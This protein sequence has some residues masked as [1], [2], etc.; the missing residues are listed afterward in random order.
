MASFEKAKIIKDSSGDY[1]LI[2]AGVRVFIDTDKEKFMSGMEQLVRLWP[3]LKDV[4][5]NMIDSGRG[6]IMAVLPPPREE[7]RIPVKF[8]GAHTGYFWILPDSVSL[9]EAAVQLYGPDHAD[10]VGFWWWFA[11]NHPEAFKRTLAFA[12]G[13][14]D[15]G[16]EIKKSFTW[17]YALG[18]I[19]VA[20]LLLN[21]I[22][23]MQRGRR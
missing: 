14:D 23:G 16:K 13:V 2:P 9:N 11:T 19:A 5:I 22:S 20:I 15:A 4:N 10:P 3:E 17:I 21:V 1:I 8:A 6:Q 18:G 12:E 7:V